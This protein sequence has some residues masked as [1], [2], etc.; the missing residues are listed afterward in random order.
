MRQSWQPW[1]DSFGTLQQGAA[2]RRDAPHP[3]SIAPLAIRQYLHW[4]GDNK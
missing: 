3:L 4:E 1:P 2:M